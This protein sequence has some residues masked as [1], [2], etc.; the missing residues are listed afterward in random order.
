MKDIW[1][2]LPDDLHK[3]D[4]IIYIYGVTPESLSIFTMT[5]NENIYVTSFVRGKNTSCENQIDA[6][7]K[8]KVI[9]PED[10]QENSILLYPS[11]E[12]ENSDIISLKEKA[13]EIIPVEIQKLN[14][15]IE[16]NEVIIYG[17]G[18]RGKRTAG[19]L[20]ENGVKVI[21]FADSDKGKIGH[22]V[23]VDN[24]DS[25]EI[26]DIDCFNKDT[27]V[28]I[29]SAYYIEIYQLLAQKGFKSI[30]CDYSQ[31]VGNSYPYVIIKNTNGN[32]SD[33]VWHMRYILP[34]FF[35]YIYDKKII[36]YGYNEYGKDLIRILSLL[37]EKI[38]YCIDDDIKTEYD[39]CDF[40]VKNIYDILYEDLSDK[41]IIV[42]N[43]KKRGEKI[44]DKVTEG[45]LF[46]INEHARR[47][48]T[49]KAVNIKLSLAENVKTFVNIANR[50]PF[51]IDLRVGRHVVDGK[52]ILGIFSL[53]L[54]K[55]ITLEVY[56][57]H[58]DDLMEELK[59]FIIG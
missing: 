13:V 6:I 57:D 39:I 21:G 7:F 24:F 34:D 15:V 8:K 23:E 55:P 46:L 54:S 22:K 9:V 56:A 37:D 16:N 51:D 47:P 33:V 17:T 26:L 18:V 20:L 29:S 32:V 44:Y 50:Y 58:C 3:T 1:K 25:L 12:S 36:I 19:Y 38:D 2:Y 40:E 14:E 11:D 10:I 43:L 30:F 27:P 31:L 41:M 45:L 53:D 28:I 5:L 59:P 35:N 52:S 49:M 4:K 48:E 42:C